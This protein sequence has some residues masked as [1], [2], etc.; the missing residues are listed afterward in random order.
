MVNRN[1]GFFIAPSIAKTLKPFSETKYTIRPTNNWI[2]QI[3][4]V[5]SEIRKSFCLKNF[6]PVSPKMALTEAKNS[7]TRAA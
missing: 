2:W 6:L 7:N 3:I 1:S 5:N 4:I